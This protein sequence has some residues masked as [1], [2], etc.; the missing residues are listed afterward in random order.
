MG[1]K[2]IKTIGSGSFGTVYL[3]QNDSLNNFALKRINLNELAHNDFRRQL[4]EIS[5]LFFNKCPCL[6]KGLDIN[7]INSQYLDI[8]TPYYDGGTLDNFISLHKSTGIKIN[9]AVIL[10]L[11]T[12]IAIGLKYLHANDIIHRDIKP[13]NILVDHKSNPKN[14]TIIDFGV[15]IILPEGNYNYARTKIGTPYFMSPEQAEANRKYNNKCDVWA[16]GCILYEMVTLEK[17]FQA[18]SIQ[19]LNR[20]KS[21]GNYKEIFNPRGDKLLGLFGKIISMCLTPSDLSRAGISDIL[22]LIELETNEKINYK[23][24]KTKMNIP[25]YFNKAYVLKTDIINCAS[26]IKKYINYKAVKEGKDNIVSNDQVP[27]VVQNK[28]YQLPPLNKL[29]PISKPR[30]ENQPQ[31]PNNKLP[32]LLKPSQQPIPIPVTKPIIENQPQNPNNKL[33]P[34][35]KPIQLPVIVQKNSNLPQIPWNYRPNQFAR[36]NHLLRDNIFPYQ[37]NLIGLPRIIAHQPRQR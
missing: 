26:E 16:L 34:L 31:I 23:Y 35:N 15:S 27:P 13:A 7:I 24:S 1:F 3:V 17:P 12:D 9:P 36:Q 10:D 6:L 21:F 37:A 19:A 18:H 33:P 20:K 11:F 28:F 5:V 30:I 32:P 14:A 8:V 29:T 2:I 25:T 22:D 4:H